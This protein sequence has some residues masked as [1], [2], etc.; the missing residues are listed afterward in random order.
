MAHFVR[1]LALADSLDTSQYDVHFYAPARF[2]RYLKGKSFAV[3]ELQSTPGERFLENTAKGAP[4]FPADVIRD[5]IR[6][7]R[8]LIGSIGPD[9]VIGDMR[10]SLPVSARL[11]GA[12]SAVMINAYW[13]PYTR[14]R[15]ILPALPLTR[16]VPPRLLGP[17]AQTGRTPGVYHPCR[18]NESSAE[19][20]RNSA[21]SRGSSRD[22]YGGRLRPIPGYPRVRAGLKPPSE[23]SL[24][25]YLPLDD[26]NRET[27]LVGPHAG[28]SEAQGI[29]QFGQFGAAPRAS[30]A[31]GGLIQAAR[32]RAHCDIGTNHAAP[33]ARC[34]CRRSATLHR[35]S[36]AGQRS[37]LSRR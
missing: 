37:G 9:L 21:A 19:G 32:L 28:G 13:S 36:R 5:Y 34:V 35:D 31:A 14:R 6:Q 26:A 25:R 3:G 12:R 27:G 24:C 15:S 17:V 8:D 20:F 2:F 1:P 4:L 30:R 10:L 22:V 7:D 29:C 33:R 18:R 23:P 16:V 11:E